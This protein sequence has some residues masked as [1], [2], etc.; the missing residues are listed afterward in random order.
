MAL[1]ASSSSETR[2]VSPASRCT[3]LETSIRSPIAPHAFWISV[4][5]SRYRATVSALSSVSGVCRNGSASTGQPMSDAPY[6]MVS[7]STMPW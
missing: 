7:W 2:A 5:A 3:F 6:L 1:S 4:S